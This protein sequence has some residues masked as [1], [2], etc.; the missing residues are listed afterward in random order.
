[1]YP[2]TCISTH[3]R[4]RTHASLAVNQNYSDLIN[5]RLQSAVYRKDTILLRNLLAQTNFQSIINVSNEEG[6]TVLHNA[7]EQGDLE[8]IRILVEAGADISAL[9]SSSQ[10]PLYSAVKKNQPAIVAVLLKSNEFTDATDVCGKTALQYA[11]EHPRIHVSI[12][13]ALLKKSSCIQKVYARVT[14]L[15]I[16][17]LY[18]DVAIVSK[19][20]EAGTDVN[21]CYFGQKTALHLAVEKPSLAIAKCLIE[22]GAHL[23]IKDSF[24]Y[25]PLYAAVKNRHPMLVE[26][27]LSKGADITIKS[28]KGITAYELAK[29]LDNQEIFLLFLKYKIMASTD[30]TES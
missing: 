8:I 13:E 25:T 30:R 1:M 2:L 19:V 7:V 20:I 21:A 12:I 9:N 16:A 27:L 17:V 22:A 3:S 28:S 26:L 14:M 10:T 23:D 18:R 4:T 15:H 29:Q 11:L 24:E 6:D 5:I